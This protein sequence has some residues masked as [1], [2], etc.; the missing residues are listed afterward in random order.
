MSLSS[1]LPVIILF[2]GLGFILLIL[3]GIITWTIR[4]SLRLNKVDIP[5]LKFL[6][7]I[8]FLQILLGVITI[9]I[10]FIVG[11]ITDEPFIAIGTGS[12]ITLLSGILFIK[13]ILKNGWKQ[14]LRV[15]AIAVAM[16]L[17]LVPVC[18]VVMSVALVMFLLLVYP[19]QY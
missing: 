19:P 10:L 13:L 2:L 5:K 14:S 8:A 11:P 7:S 9:F 4:I 16:Q 12:G 17:V 18:S 6:F 1:T 15:W 3:C